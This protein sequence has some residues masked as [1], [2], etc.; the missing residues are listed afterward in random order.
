[1]GDQLSFTTFDFDTLQ[2]PTPKTKTKSKKITEKIYTVS[3]L[4]DEINSILKPLDYTVQGE[5][6]RI[7]ERGGAIYFTISDKEE[8]AILD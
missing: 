3:Q 5:I 4:L 2:K 7:S 1:M 8:K 6:S